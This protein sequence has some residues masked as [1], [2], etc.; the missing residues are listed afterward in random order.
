[1]VSQVLKEASIPTRPKTPVEKQELV[2][3]L[4]KQG[5]GN[6]E[7][8]KRAGCSLNVIYRLKKRYH[9]TRPMSFMTEDDV[10]RAMVL[11]EEGVS[12]RRIGEVLGYSD[13]AIR[14]HLI[15]IEVPIRTQAETR[16][17]FRKKINPNYQPGR[18]ITQD[19][20]VLVFRPDHPKAMKNGYIREHRLVAE[21]MIGRQLRDD[22]IPHHLNGIKDDNRPENLCVLS[23]KTHAGEMRLKDLYIKELQKRI[24]QLETEVKQKKLL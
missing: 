24:R 2:I 6:A 13:T 15:E 9:S 10:R 5:I 16:R 18:M 14:N 4:L 11:Y 7:I 22:E 3:D 23:L 17:F 20:Y 12:L 8:H 1:M 19:G 21:Q